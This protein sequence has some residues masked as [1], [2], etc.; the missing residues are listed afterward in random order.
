MD[1]TL[2]T[3]FVVDDEPAVLDS[4]TFL[5]ESVGL[6]VESF[7]TAQAFLDGY[8][9]DRPGCLVLDVRL[10]GIS[11][12]ELQ[13]RMLQTGIHLPVILITGNADVPMAVRGMKSGAVDFLEKPFND[14]V[15][16]ECVEKALHADD[17][18]RSVRSQRSSDA[19]RLA[20]LT[21]REAEVVAMVA[22]GSANK[23]IAK[24]LG[25]TQKTVELHRANAMRKLGAGHVSELV[26]IALRSRSQP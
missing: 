21:P 22:S 13:E 4:L 8:T 16:L 26:A 23:K 15:L 9:G 3:V 18:S 7:P 10:P 12:L 11:G 25:I 19:A 14:Q 5:L 17:R 2:A 1:R 24:A 20:L 6:R